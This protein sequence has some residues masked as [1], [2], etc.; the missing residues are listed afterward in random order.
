[1]PRLPLVFVIVAVLLIAGGRFGHR[2]PVAIAGYGAPPGRA[3]AE[4]VR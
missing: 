4:F 2:G 1:M 3:S